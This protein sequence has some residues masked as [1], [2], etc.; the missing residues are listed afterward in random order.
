MKGM[1]LLIGVFALA[2]SLLVACGDRD[3]P[4][5]ASG[6]QDGQPQTSV[7]GGMIAQN[8][9][10]TFNGQ[11]YELVNMLQEDLVN[12][13]EFAAVGTVETADVDLTDMQAYR[14]AGDGASVYTHSEAGA[15]NVGHWLAWRP[16]S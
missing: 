9:F 11:Q 7:G 15:G 12:P 13:T 6:T 8:V 5:V 1:T 16:V 2:T 4:P 3:A 14:R 10:L